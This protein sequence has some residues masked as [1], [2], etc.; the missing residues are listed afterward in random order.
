[1][2]E[3]YYGELERDDWGLVE[4]PQLRCYGGLVFGCWD[5]EAPA[6]EDYLGDLCW[7]L[8]T[9]IMSEDL[10]GL[11][12][13]PGCQRYAIVGNWKL[14]CDNFAGD[15]YHVLTSHASAF[16][17]TA[18]GNAYRDRN[19]RAV[20][21]MVHL[22]PAHGLGGISIGDATYQSDVARA[23]E[24]GSDV[25]EY[26]E[27]R[28]RQ[29]QERLGAR[30]SKLAGWTWGQVFPNLNLQAFDSALR[31]RIFAL[32]LPK[33]PDASEIWQ[34][35]LVERNAPKALKEF[36]ART[37]NRG[38]SGSGLI[39]VD[40]TENFERITEVTRTPMSRKLNFNYA[41]SIGLEGNWPDRDHW[42]LKG[43][44]GYFGP[45]F[46]ETGQRRFYQYW[47]ELMGM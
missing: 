45:H 36:V 24:L 8:D 33:G 28:H 18:G 46:W 27:E 16:S 26:V 4:V 3:A 47:A 37:A 35:N 5:P 2:N 22:P 10:G 17:V 30:P 42:D 39:G 40:D 32:C 25:V 20:R 38:Q 12:A 19:G 15:G 34:W 21:S 11:E 13:L 6:L 41:M 9:L 14:F 29:L 43:L 31:G 7:Y 1:L 44:P 23:Q